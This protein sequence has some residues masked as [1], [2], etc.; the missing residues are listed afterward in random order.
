MC[1]NW[2]APSDFPGP[3]AMG[4][5]QGWHWQRCSGAGQGPVGAGHARDWHSAGTAM[6]S[7]AFLPEHCYAMCMGNYLQ[8]CLSSL[9]EKPHFTDSE[10]EETHPVVREMTR[11]VKEMKTGET[12]NAMIGRQLWNAAC[13]CFLCHLICCLTCSSSKKETK[14]SLA[15]G[16][17]EGKFGAGFDSL[18]IG[19]KILR[20]TV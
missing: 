2:P 3:A 19:S 5:V 20:I 10:R 9:T 8:E 15:S 7:W 11:N 1:C 18:Y 12:E 14:Y 16:S 13:F 17:K 4:T 6:P